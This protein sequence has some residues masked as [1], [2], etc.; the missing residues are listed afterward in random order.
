ME[1]SVVRQRIR[2]L[3]ERAKRTPE[4]HRA[5][6]RAQTDAATKEYGLFLD[7]IAVPLFKQVANVLRADNYAFDVF[8]PG[9]SVRLTSGRGNDDY[10]EIALD[11]KGAAPKLL[12]RVSRTR[13]GDLA[14]TELVLNATTDIG[15]LTEDDLLG[16]LLS[17]LEAFV[18]A[19]V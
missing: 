9:G 3:I 13:G 19:R 16:F 4:D 8:T 15:A 5:D 11:T 10:I 12:G 7:R 1:V 14:Q 17:E 18:E 2:A 6:R